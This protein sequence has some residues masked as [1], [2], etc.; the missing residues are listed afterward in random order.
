MS[1][2]FPAVVLAAAV[3]IALAGC[4]KHA[5]IVA[6]TFKDPVVFDDSFGAYVDFQA[7]LG[8]K[9][10]AIAI[11]STEAYS[12]TAS[13]RVTVPPAGDPSGTYAGGAFTSSRARD[14]TGYDALTFWAKSSR[15]V[16]F[17]IVGIGNDNTGTSRY[18]ASR[19]SLAM[20]S[21]WKRFVVPIPL[22]SRLRD[23]KGLFYFA[24][25]PEAGQGATVWFDEIRFEKLLTVTD[26]RPAI[27]TKTLTPDVGSYFDVSGTKVTFAVDGAD[28]TVDCMQGYFTFASSADSVVRG[29]EGTLFAA[30]LGLATV[31]ASLGG[32]AAAGTLTV[33]PNAAPQSPAPTPT[34]PAANVISLFS[35]AYTNVPVDTWSASWD[36]A[37]LTD[38]QIAGND[39]KRYS[40]LT[41]AG[42]EFITHEI[43]ATA[44][45]HFHLDVWIPHG[46]SFKVKLV[47]FGADG[48][49][50]GG[51]DTSSEL[52]FTS[53]TTPAVTLGTWCSLEI[54]L[55]S[56][57]S[58]GLASRSHLAQL[59]LSGDPGTAYIDNVYFHD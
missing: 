11:D 21:A 33:T 57:T 5:G 41:Y 43:D 15:N 54:P 20:T 47:D 31:T 14:L 10:D 50:G 34:V 51:D 17:D 44:M 26:P 19:S 30:G 29:G 42:I 49:Y 3:T 56:F 32:V 59:L 55:T 25:G 8:S 53:A 4:A 7:F 52:T 23:E 46:T 45:T 38:L 40:N 2:R 12:G 48:V 16:T 39:V 6:P 58:T 9:V 36:L 27:P 1:R 28:V 18:T 22:A 35:N 13:I 24:E 37:D